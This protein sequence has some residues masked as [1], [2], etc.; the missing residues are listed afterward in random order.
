MKTSTKIA[1]GA[2]FL[3]S[4][5]WEWVG[6][7]WDIIMS[8]AL[9]ALVIGFVLVSRKVNKDQKEIGHWGGTRFG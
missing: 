3:V 2:Y 7:N 1:L 6:T 8:V 4:F 9:V 5:I